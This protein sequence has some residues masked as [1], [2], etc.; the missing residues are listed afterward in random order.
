VFSQYAD[1]KTTYP[2]GFRLYEKEA[3]SKIDHAKALV[4]E[5]HEVGV[6]AD[7]YLFD[8]WYCSQEL[9]KHVESY[10]KDWISVLK[11]NRHV[12]YGG[13]MIRVD[14]LEKPEMTSNSE[15]YHGQVTVV[16]S[17]SP[18]FSGPPVCVHSLIA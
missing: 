8:S 14:A 3:E 5:A 9:V 18:P 12:E 2:L 10:D 11:S 6:S 13:E 15:P 16:P 17:R 4:D 1:E 7:T